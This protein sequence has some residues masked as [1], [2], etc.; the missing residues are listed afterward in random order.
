MAP[1]RDGW[2]VN[3]PA[4]RYGV[5]NPAERR[6]STPGWRA[7]LWVA[8]LLAAGLWAIVAA[9]VAV[10]MELAHVAAGGG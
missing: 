6:L 4:H 1:G 5:F 8:V 7:P 9:L 10:G 3:M 2:R